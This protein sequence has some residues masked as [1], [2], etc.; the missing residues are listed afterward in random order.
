MHKTATTTLVE[1]LKDL[2]YDVTTES[3]KFHAVVKGDIS[4]CIRILD[5]TNVVRDI[6][7]FKLYKQLDAVI[8]N[9]KFILTVRD[10][11]KWFASV[12]RHI[13]KLRSARHEWVYGRNKGI[14]SEDK[15]HTLNVYREHNAEVMDYFKYRMSDLLVLDFAKY[16]AWFN[17]C[18]FLDRPMPA[19][20]LPQANRADAREARTSDWQIRRRKLKEW[21]KIRYYRLQGLI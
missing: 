18:A 8:P 2:G 21:F 1:C 15:E 3:P 16:D 11:E 19:I 10:E 9:C 20:P 5:N 12:D 17:L 6:P 14:P 4:G 7:W 13:G